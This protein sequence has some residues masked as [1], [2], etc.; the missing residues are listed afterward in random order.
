LPRAY[1]DL[2]LG[3]RT[4]GSIP[5][6]LREPLAMLAVNDGLFNEVPCGE[7][8][9]SIAVVTC[10]LERVEPSHYA[11]GLRPPVLLRV[12]HALGAA[13]VHHRAVA[14]HAVCDDGVGQARHVL[15]HGFLKRGIGR[16]RE[17]SPRLPA[18]P[19]QPTRLDVVAVG[20]GVAH[21]VP[22]LVKE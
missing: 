10:E 22:L 13:F 19:Q 18:L 16:F 15:P 1:L 17:R 6:E 14:V 4:R 20:D 3:T 2:T 5:L 8:S 9:I 7:S 11:F 12:A 21:H